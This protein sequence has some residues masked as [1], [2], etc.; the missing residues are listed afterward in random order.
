MNVASDSSDD[1]AE[2]YIAC[3]PGQYMNS[4][5]INYYADFRRDLFNNLICG[6]SSLVAKM[7]C[8]SCRGS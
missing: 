4:E 1:T 5:L 6:S 7:Q 2:V 8:D 3:K